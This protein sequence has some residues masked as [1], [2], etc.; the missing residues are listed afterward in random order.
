[1]ENFFL[2]I[3][4]YAICIRKMTGFLY[5]KEGGGKK[6]KIWRHCFRQKQRIRILCVIVW[7]HKENINFINGEVFFLSPLSYVLFLE[8]FWNLGVLFFLCLIFR[9]FLCL[10]SSD[11][12]RGGGE[13]GERGRKRKKKRRK[14]NLTWI[15]HE[16]AVHHHHLISSHL[17]IE[18]KPFKFQTYFKSFWFLRILLYQVVDFIYK[19]KKKR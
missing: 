6:R 13:W 4:I 8:F 7:R 15:F 19:K 3:I 12:G 1:M 11:G 2:I 16:E 14:I 5:L 17:L 10:F 18:V 9:F